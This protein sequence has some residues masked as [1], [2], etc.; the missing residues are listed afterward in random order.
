MD[1]QPAPALQPLEPFKLERFFAKWEFAAPHLLC[2]SDSEPLT[3]EQLL[4]LADS[5]ARRRWQQLRLAYTETQG[6]P[7][8]R[9]AIVAAHYTSLGPEHVVVAAPQEALYLCMQALLRPG[10]RV[11][12]CFPG[13]QSLYSV[14]SSL[15]CTLALWE[16]GAAADGSPRFQL[17]AA[18]RLI[19]PGTRLVVVNSPHNP[20]GAHFSLDEWRELC[21]LCREVGAHLF[22]WDGWVA[23][24]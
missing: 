6:L 23:G 9:E 16:L 10:D 8:L 22:R 17:G 7:A 4:A 3:M 1:G 5:D 12:C 20:S 13:Y 21:G 18:R 2:C 15:G 19:T 14:A 24:W 11:V